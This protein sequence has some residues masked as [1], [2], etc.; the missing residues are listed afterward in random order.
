MAKD[1]DD[2]RPKMFHKADDSV[3]E[4]VREMIE[5]HHPDLAS[6]DI[7]VGVVMVY[8]ALNKDG[9]PTGHAV[10][11]SGA[12]CAAKI[13]KVPAKDRVHTP[14]DVRIEIDADRWSDLP[15]ASRRALIDHELEHVVVRKDDAGTPITDDDLRPKLRLKPDDWV[16]TGFQCVVDRHG[17]SALEAMALHTLWDMHGQGL[18][19]WAKD[20]PK[21]NQSKRTRAA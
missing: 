16:L 15:K 11:L 3:M 14:F 4:I 18:F 12:A 20:A 6:V 17:D 19:S 2:S 1:K 8:P 7:R 9:E 5:E 10:S 13:R 21:N